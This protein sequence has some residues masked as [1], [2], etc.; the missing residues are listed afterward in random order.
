MEKLKRALTVSNVLSAIVSVIKFTGRFFDVFGNPQKKGRW[1][2]WGDSSS[3]KSSFIMQLI[4][5]F[6]KTEKTILVSREEDLD[7]ENL[8]DRLKLFQ[9]QDVA[10]NF[11]LVDDTL[12]Q[13]IERLERRNSA[14]VVVIDSVAY[15]F[16]GYTFEDYLNFRKRFKD[17]TLVFVGHGKGQNP[18]TEFEDRIK[19]DATQK[20]VVSGYL[21]TNKGRKYGPHATQYV[22]WEKGYQDLHGQQK[23]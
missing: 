1:F 19:F 21:A 23:N 3:G 14:Q 22:V 6:A 18:K 4:K 7:D 10:K 12:E 20:V 17:K 9:M 8:Q 16:M 15:F 5:E 11:S 2:I 13:L